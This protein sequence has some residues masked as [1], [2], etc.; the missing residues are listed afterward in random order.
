MIV[1]KDMQSDR[2]HRDILSDAA[3]EIER[4]REA[5]R[6]ITTEK[7]EHETLRMIALRALKE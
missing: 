1:A 5:L 3:N 2:F 6:K 7:G 4:L